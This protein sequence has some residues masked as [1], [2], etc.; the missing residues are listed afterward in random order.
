MTSTI[1]ADCRAVSGAR[2][3]VIWTSSMRC[4]P[5]LSESAA[6]S[7]WRVAIPDALAYVSVGTLNT[8][9]RTTLPNAAKRLH[10][11]RLKCLKT[12]AERWLNNVVFISACKGNNFFLLFGPAGA[13]FFNLNSFSI[14]TISSLKALSVCSR[15]STCEQLCSTVEWSR[16]PTSLPI[17]LAG[18]L[19]YFEARY[20]D[21]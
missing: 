14:P 17:R 5:K 1:L 18:I 3:P 2:E 11:F 6:S 20:I 19:V 21:T 16:L 12:I 9:I 15:C 13:Y 4:S 10:P 8:P 7:V